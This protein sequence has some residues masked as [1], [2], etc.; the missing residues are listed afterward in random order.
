MLAQELVASHWF[1]PEATFALMAV[2]ALAALGTVAVFTVSLV[3][4]LRRK[5]KPYLLITTALGLLVLRSVVGFLTV[6]DVL[7]MHLH[8]LLEHTFDFAI[9]VL[10]LY[11]AWLTGSE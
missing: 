5:T 1:D 2:I 6:Y 9:A 4:Y 8:H 10:I 3:A 7:P 11:A